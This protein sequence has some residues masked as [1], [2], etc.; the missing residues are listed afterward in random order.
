MKKAI[1]L[2]ILLAGLAFIAGCCG[3]DVPETSRFETISKQEIPT[4]HGQQTLLVVR[5]SISGL[6]WGID[7]TLRGAFGPIPCE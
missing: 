3:L 5:D 1:I 2:T 4:G 6:C 7:D